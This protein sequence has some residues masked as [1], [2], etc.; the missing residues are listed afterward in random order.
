MLLC[1]QAILNICPE[2][3]S[4]T[5]HK[6]IDGPFIYYYIV[7]CQRVEKTTLSVIKKKK[8]VMTSIIFAD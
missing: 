2:F 3:V 8:K 5:R 4:R 7:Y 1:F 6:S